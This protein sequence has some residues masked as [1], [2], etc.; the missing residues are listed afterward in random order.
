MI[1][2]AA[3]SLMGVGGTGAFAADYAAIAAGAGG[4]GWVKGGYRSMEGARAAARRNCIRGGHGGCDKTVAERSD[5]YYSGGNCDGVTYV[6][7]SRQGWWRSDEIVRQ[8]AAR[9]GNY[10]CEIEVQF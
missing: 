1:G 3:V 6:G 2:V 8:K 10:N 4:Y 7:T 9:D 5:W